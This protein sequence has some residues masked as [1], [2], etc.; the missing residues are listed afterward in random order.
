M[1]NFMNDIIEKIKNAKSFDEIAEIKQF[2]YEANIAGDID[3]EDVL[4]GLYKS[5]TRFIFELLQNAE[6]AGAT[7]IEINLDEKF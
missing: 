7:N 1:V 2:L 6:D 3:I 4:A 5:P